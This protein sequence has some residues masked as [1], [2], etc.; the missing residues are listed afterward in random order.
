VHTNHTRKLSENSAP[1]T[2]SSGGG[3]R[4]R[5][6]FPSGEAEASLTKE[7]FQHGQQ[8]LGLLK[9]KVKYRKLDLLRELQ[10]T[11]TTEQ[12]F[13]E[14]GADSLAEE[15]PAYQTFSQEWEF[16]LEDGE[17]VEVLRQLTP[18]QQEVVWLLLAGWSQK[19][20]ADHLGLTPA[21]VSQTKNRAYQEIRKLYRKG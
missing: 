1:A 6:D 11:A 15:A 19:E 20:I 9:Q 4:G 10:K 17:L 5:P 2:P 8:L 16:L 12:T 18:R 13:L 14:E 7:D 3:K 21:A